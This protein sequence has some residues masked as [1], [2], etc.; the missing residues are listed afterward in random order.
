MHI[1]LTKH[2][3]EISLQSLAVFGSIPL[4]N[5]L[6]G[7]VV[8]ALRNQRRDDPADPDQS[9]ASHHMLNAAEVVKRQLGRSCCL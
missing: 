4:C 5:A 9:S 3:H 7:R 1:A 6:A 8:A 2:L